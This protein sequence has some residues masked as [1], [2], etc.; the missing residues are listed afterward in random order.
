M[1]KNTTKTK[2][3]VKALSKKSVVKSDNCSSKPKKAVFTN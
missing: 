2:L 1:R 3:G